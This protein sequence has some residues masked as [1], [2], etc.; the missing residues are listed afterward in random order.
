MKNVGIVNYKMGNLRSIK[1]SL[2]Y[3]GI[4]NEL[5][6]TK[7]Q[8]KSKTHLILPGVGSFKQAMKNLDELKLI[9]PIKNFVKEKKILGICLGMQ[10]L[11][12]S[13]TEQSL[14]NGLN[15]VNMK[16]ERFKNSQLKNLK[17]PHIGFNTITVEK[18]EGKFFRNIKQNSDFYFVHSFKTKNFDSLDSYSC[19]NYG[20]NFVAA[21]SKGNIFGTQFHPEKSQSNGAIILKNF[22]N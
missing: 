7:E 15:L 17:I 3:F 8:I 5:V 19:C 18:D 6:D 16:F 1:N 22:L 11:G 10:L 20:E 13:S 2:N 12:K 14:S 4:K 21:F 9:D